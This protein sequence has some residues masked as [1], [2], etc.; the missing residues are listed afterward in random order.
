AVARGE[1]ERAAELLGTAHSVIG[2]EDAQGHDRR[3]V[4]AAVLPILGQDVFDAAYE[5][6]RSA[7]REDALALTP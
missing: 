4:M 3:R 6:G 2:F 7:T 5:R 1:H